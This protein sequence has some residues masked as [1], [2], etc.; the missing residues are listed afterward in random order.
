MY[1][2]HHSYNKSK[3]G[4]KA[5]LLFT[6]TNSLV[7][8]IETCDVQEDFYEYLCFTLL[9]ILKIKNSVINQSKK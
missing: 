1:D 2:F 4:D 3:Y 6:D 5:K 8:E 9:N 7:Y